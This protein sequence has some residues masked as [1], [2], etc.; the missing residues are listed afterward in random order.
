[1]RCRRYI[2]MLAG[3]FALA[4][5]A[6]AQM[7]P[8]RD[9]N[10]LVRG[11]Y[12]PLPAALGA[13]GDG[14]WAFAAGVQWS[15]TVNI[16][17]TATERMRVDEE[18]VEADLSASRGFGAWQ[19]R[20]TLPVIRRSGGVLD[21]FIDGW[22]SFFHLP[23]GDRPSLAKNAYAIS[24]R[25]SGL[26]PLDASAGTALGD[27]ALEAGRTLSAT[28]AGRLEGW[29]GLEAPTGSRARL[30]GDGALD[31]AAW[32]AGETRL[33]ASWALAGRAGAA[34][35]GGDAGGLPLARAIGFATL[36]LDWA[37]SERLGAVLQ[38]DAHSALARGSDL[39]FL[40]EAVALTIGGRYRLGGGAVFEAG[41]VE[42]IEVD[43][44]PDVTFHFG[45]RWPAGRAGR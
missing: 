27:L 29:L 33:G 32:L 44:S 45:M 14:R 16:E 3:A 2:L 4:G 37:A 22:H 39:R 30:T 24:Y 41:V 6:T 21:G 18:T 23:T 15:N 43:H 8:V 13:A 1:M 17:Q 9:Q 35:V 20:A 40:R 19:L 31:A 36:A 10:P 5:P 25:R 28:P 42:D 11:A 26:A 7:L 38:L 12:L 34:Y